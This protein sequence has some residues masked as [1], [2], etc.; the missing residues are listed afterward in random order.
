MAPDLASIDEDVLIGRA[1]DRDREA[2]GELSRRYEKSL[3]NV[4]FGVVGD[5]DLAQDVTQETFLR[6]FRFLE[7]YRKTF[8]FSTWLFRIGVNLGISKL[9]RARLESDVFSAEGLRHHG[10]LGPGGGLTPVDRALMEER[11]RE[12]V[13]AV[14]EL[15][16]RYRTVLMMRYGEGMSCR[17]IGQELGISA[18][19]VSI[20]LHR[21]KLKLKEFLEVEGGE[22]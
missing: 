8:R 13:R 22:A 9:R 17:D 18:N 16:E 7:H 21:G 15:S 5:A 20:I 19:S 6:A 10:I 14:G 12:V 4:V 1:L 11:A 2:F 3:Y